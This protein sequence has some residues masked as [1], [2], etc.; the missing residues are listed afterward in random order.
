MALNQSFA[1]AYLTNPVSFTVGNTTLGKIIVPRT[2]P[3]AALD[4]LQPDI[5][6]RGG[7]RLIGGQISS[8]DGTARSI[9]IYEGHRCFVNTAGVLTVGSSSTI[10]R[11]TGS[12]LQTAATATDN[13]GPGWQVG[14]TL[15]LF[16]SATGA[17]NGLLC[18]V[19]G[20]SASTLTVNGTP[21]TTDATP[22]VVTELYRV[23]MRT[24]IG[25]PLNSG[26]TD[27]APP[28]QLFGS[29]QDVDLASQ[30]DRGSQFGPDDVL[31]GAMVANISALPAAITVTPH[32]ALY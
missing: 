19:T 28:V 9:L 29:S 32:V 26:N 2:P 6:L 7:C 11:S 30:P 25:I 31:I 15:M 21:L 4:T 13:N 10:V 3:A 18:V 17:N 22:G 27:S 23:A 5:T 1:G 14:D 12:F 16:Y 24:R 8:T 20:V